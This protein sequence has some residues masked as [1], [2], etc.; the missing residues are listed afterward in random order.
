MKA[1]IIPLGL[2]ACCLA[3]PHHGAAEEI[4]YGE[5]QDAIDGDLLDRESRVE[6]GP[7]EGYYQWKERFA[8]ETGFNYLIEY[9]AIAQRG[10]SGGDDFH[11][12]HE[13][14]LI[15][16]WDLLRSPAVGN[17]R[18]IGWFQNSVTLNDVTTTEF[19]RSLGVLSPV[20]GGDTF[21]D[22]SANRIQNFAWEQRFPDDRFRIMVGKLTTRV[23]MNLNRYAVSDREDFFSPMIVNNPVAPF[24][25]RIGPGI[26]GEFRTDEWYLSALVRDAAAT[27]DYLGFDT[28]G[29][30]EGE[31]SAE[32]GWTPEFAGIGEGIYRFM[33]SYTDEVTRA[34]G[35][36]PSGWTYSLSCDQD[37]GERLGAFARYACSDDTFRAFDQRLAAGIQIKEPLGC[38]DDRIGFAGWWGDPSD[39]A[40]RDEFGLEAFWSLQLTRGFALTP[41]IQVIFDPAV[42]PRHDVAF[43]AALRARIE[44]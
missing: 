27:A 15:A 39:P 24:T 18:F 16:M 29:N 41:G 33:V 34:T 43:A 35:N 25:A 20:N 13:L 17:G 23:L 19:M 5:I 14:N 31:Y 30:G 22:R 9:G 11:A 21:P 6:A 26:F 4:G 3:V 10:F 40:L 12:D 37:I 42:D 1:T 2:A 8:E 7:L 28:V 36:L 32:F 38:A 44:L